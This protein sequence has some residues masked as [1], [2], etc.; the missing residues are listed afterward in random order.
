MLQLDI[1]ID[2]AANSQTLKQFSRWRLVDDPE[3]LGPADDQ[4][5]ELVHSTSC[6]RT[7]TCHHRQ[8]FGGTTGTTT[9]AI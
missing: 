2:H 7:A 1:Y 8:H 3:K 6:R 5:A 4:Q 9:S